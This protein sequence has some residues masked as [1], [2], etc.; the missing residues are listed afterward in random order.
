MR[1][2]D[3]F[4]LICTE[5][6]LECRDFYV[7]HFGFAVEF[8]STIYTQVKV[9]SET[10]GHFSIAFMPPSHPFGEAYR[11]I[12]SGRGA[13]L[14]IQVADAAAVHERVVALGAPIV[15]DL[16]DEDWG[17]RHFITRDPNGTVVDV[18]QAIEPAAGYYDRYTLR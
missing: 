14:T 2:Q 13:Y 4:V 8:E 17:Q 9:A 7:R 10:G 15:A 5:K 16:R 1:I 18:V 3:L 11:D 12:F 6:M